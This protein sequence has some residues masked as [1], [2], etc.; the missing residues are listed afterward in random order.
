MK[1]LARALPFVALSV[2]VVA[3]A[4]F[5]GIDQLGD[6][7]V[8]FINQTLVPLIFAIAFLVFLWGIFT[9]FILGKDNEEKR[10][11]GTQY[12]MWGIIGFVIMVSVW[13]IVNLVA[14]SLNLDQTETLQN[15]PDAPTEND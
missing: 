9:H 5:G 12:M 14:G 8:E 10:K 7:V 1:F 3:L 11:E 15:I 13:G 6:N 2:P 4:Q